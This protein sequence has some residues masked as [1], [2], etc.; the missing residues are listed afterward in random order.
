MTDGPLIGAP[1]NP[2]PSPEKNPRIYADLKT[3]PGASKSA[4]FQNF[5][6]PV[7]FDLLC[8]LVFYLV[9]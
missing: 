1:L 6:T 7:L 3:G 2:P 4:L 5:T 8:D 9:T